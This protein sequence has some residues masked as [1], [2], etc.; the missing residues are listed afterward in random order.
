[1]SE[2]VD[3]CRR[4]WRRLGVADPIANEMATDLN[5]D[6][7]EAASEGGS[8]EDV[9][10][11]SAFDPRRFAAAWAISRGVAGAPTPGCSS[12]W[13]TRVVVAAVACVGA[14]VFLAGLILITGRSSRSIGIARRFVDV[15]PQG[16]LVRPGMPRIDFPSPSN[17][18]FIGVQVSGVDAFHPIALIVLVIGMI[19]VVC[20]ACAVLFGSR[21]FRTFRLLRRHDDSPN[22]KLN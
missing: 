7:E 10:G 13:R 22:A 21:G 4:E 12:R 5:A 20:L 17:L 9:L 6:L 1:M 8:P 3:E 18:P 11:N 16:Q 15:L 19:G 2:F 14:L